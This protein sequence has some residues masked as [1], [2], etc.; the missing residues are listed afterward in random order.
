MPSCRWPARWAVPG[1]ADAGRVCVLFLGGSRH[2]QV[3]ARTAGGSDRRV[4]PPD[5]ARTGRLTPFEN[6]H[7]APREPARLAPPDARAT[8]DGDGR[9]RPHDGG[10]YP[11]GSTGSIGTKA[12]A[13]T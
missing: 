3:V 8:R 2:S 5:P 11:N 6:P 4:L 10:P 12:L 13:R 7:R 9:V 1:R